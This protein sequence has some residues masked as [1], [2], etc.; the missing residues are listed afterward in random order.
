MTAQ[1]MRRWN[2]LAHDAVAVGQTLRITSDLAPNAGKAKRAA[3]TRTATAAKPKPKS[4]K[5]A[6]NA[7]K[8]PSSAK[9]GA[10]PRS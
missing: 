8:K 5:P 9:V 6:E 1:D 7:A 2:G 4:T 3:G 10:A